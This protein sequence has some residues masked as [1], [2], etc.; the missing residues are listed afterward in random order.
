[1][2]I[3]SCMSTRSP[4]PPGRKP[5]ETCTE[6]QF[7]KSQLQTTIRRNLYDYTEFRLSLYIKQVTDEQQRITLENVLASY[8]KGQVVVAW[9]SGKPVWV[10]MTKE[11]KR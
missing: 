8:K 7:H 6:F 3:D 11:T 10:P 2:K 1:M 5:G 4:Q 9:R